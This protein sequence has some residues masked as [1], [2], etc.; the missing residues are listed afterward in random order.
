MAGDTST[1]LLFLDTFKHQS[2]ELTNVDVVRFPCGVLI[3]EVRVIPPGIKAHSNLPDN[4]AFGET[5]PHA[6]QLELF[7]NNVTKPNSPTFHRLGSLEYDENKSIV[8]RPSGK[9]NT[10]GLVL[11]GWYTSL[12]LAVYGT[13]E[14]PHGHEHGSPPPPP[15]PPPQ[16]PSG[17]KRIVKQEW[18]KD[19]QYNGSPPRPAPRGPRTPPG[20]PPPDDDE[21]EQVPMAVGV[22]K[23]E[24]SQGRD[25]YLEAVS[26]ERSLPAE[27][28]FTDGEPEEE[29]EEQEEE[30]ARTEGSVQEEE[31]EEEEDEGDDGYEQISSDEDDLDNGTFKLPT[32]D[33]DYT[34]EDLASVPPVQYDP[35]ERELKPL[36]Y[37]TPPYKTRFDTQLEKTSIEEPRDA[38]ETEGA[39]CGEEAEAVAQL[40]ELLAGTGE[41]RDARWV[42]AV[43][44]A[45]GL[46]NKCL[47]YLIKQ[48]QGEAEEPV[49]I[50]VQWTLQALSMEI[51]LTQP[52]ALNLRQLKAGAKLASCL[53][54]CPQGLAKLLREGALN[55]LLELLH[56]DHVSSTLKLSILR[57]L[58]ALISAPAGVE[59]FLHAGNSEKSGYQRLVQLFLREETVRVINAGNAILQK[60]HTYEVL[61]SLQHAAAAWSEPQQ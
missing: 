49:R 16:Q 51:A 53:A 19:E 2:A 21:E 8:F 33:I 57:A 5:S 10:D 25:D 26:P 41:D 4:R 44:E 17:L 14:R 27:E 37:F 30:E 43:E 12:T 29:E 35:Y 48:G 15:P 3:T 20:P 24:P 1:E 39:A 59:A 34:P 31:E 47:A 61:V 55:V 7:F 54:E 36:A 40:K 32:F 56:A 13:A 23:D 52:I 22:V 18:E 9:V 38:G 46:L 42:T 28:T 11:R 58:D 60:S 6:F 45:P 50:L